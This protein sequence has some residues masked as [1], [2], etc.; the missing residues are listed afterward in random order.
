MMRL[1]GEHEKGSRR[2]TMWLLASALFYAASGQAQPE[3]QSPQP[4]A[5]AA[6]GERTPEPTWQWVRLR[7]D[8]EPTVS[9]CPPQPELT[10]WVNQLV[11]RAFVAE[12]AA[13]ELRILVRRSL[14][15][16]LVVELFA[17][18]PTT[19]QQPAVLRRFERGLPCSELL[20]AAALTISLFAKAPENPSPEAVLA[21]PE[22][23]PES[24]NPPTSA[25]DETGTQ[26]L[27]PSAA[28]APPAAVPN[29]TPSTPPS[30]PTETETVVQARESN[31]LRQQEM[32]PS[33]PL[34]TTPSR[35]SV[36]VGA[37]GV[38]AVGLNP[39]VGLGATLHAGVHV[40]QWDLLV[41]G[42]HLASTGQELTPAEDGSIFGSTSELLIAACPV[43][44]GRVALRLCGNVG[45]LWVYARG[46]GFD[47]DR[48]ALLTTL[49]VGGSAELLLEL[50][51]ALALSARFELLAPLAP[52]KY[53]ID[54]D[55]DASWMTWKVAPRAAIGVEWR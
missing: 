33:I 39:G 24:P 47:R 41:R 12:E 37:A 3:T 14:G 54:G 31:G 21:F 48:R 34:D 52:V 30:S 25:H 53:E 5:P 13:V 50:N 17:T 1:L 26:P 44:T 22:S 29:A 11:G 42:G 10:S 46:R 40:S 23:E 35:V 38:G 8:V 9:G 2:W 43:F 49:S 51:P 45:P 32:A 16:E 36:V 6:Q 4:T 18:D 19:S 55:P 28:T 20:R 27:A 15:D 7:V